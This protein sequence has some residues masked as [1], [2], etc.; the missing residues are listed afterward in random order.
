[1]SPLL[2]RRLVSVAETSVKSKKAG[3]GYFT[4][5]YEFPVVLGTIGIMFI[6]RRTCLPGSTEQIVVMAL[7]FILCLY[8]Q[9]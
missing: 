5:P 9:A 3:L 7:V 2:G 1:M 4:T 6:F 8:S